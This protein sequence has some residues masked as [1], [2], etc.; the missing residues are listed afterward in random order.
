MKKIAQL[1]LACLLFA[2]PVH[3][4]QVITGSYSGNGGDDRDLTI[5]PA[6][7]PVAVFIKGNGSSS[8]VVMYGTN[9]TNASMRLTDSTQNNANEIQQ[10]NSDGFQVGSGANVNSVSGITYHYLAIC[11]N[12]AGDIAQGSYTGTTGDN[13][14]VPITPAFSP[15]LVILSAATNGFVGVWRG[16]NSHSGDLTSAF[17]A[18]ANSTNWIQA[19]NADGFQVGSTFNA[20]GTY[21][22]LAIKASA[23]GVTTG[24]FT[25]DTNDDRDITTGFLPEFVLVKGSSATKGAGYR[26]TSSTALNAY[27]NQAAEATNIIQAFGA[28][29]FQ[30]GTDTCANENTIIMR[31]FA[32]ADVSPSAGGIRRR[33]F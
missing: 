21:H 19:F 18:N 9:S 23:L 27:C 1:V 24:N 14:D 10:I 22:Y 20:A 25:G 30:V 2:S 15:E 17:S 13:R 6:C 32:L 12:G 7:Q 26:F 29:T 31:W 16:A 4:I 28:T 33:G 11:D 8:L 5:S 3:A